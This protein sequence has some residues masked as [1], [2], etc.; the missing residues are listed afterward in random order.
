MN[1]VLDTSV[2]I[3]ALLSPEGP[4]AEIIK[5]WEADELGVVISPALVAELR[6]ALEY[7][8][9]R[10]YLKVPQ[11]AVD[12]LIKRLETVATL[13]EPHLSLDV[14]PEDPADNRVLEC[15]IAGNASTIVTGDA[16]LLKL[17]EVQGV[18]LLNPAAFLLL[19]KL[20]VEV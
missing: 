11:I 9:V 6:C 2:I 13:V 12:T 7:E 14:I 3:S 8:Q 4:P 16:H 10:K 19:A 18:A 17:K 1:V 20:G 5:R 15:A